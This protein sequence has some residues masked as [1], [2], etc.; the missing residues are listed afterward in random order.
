[1]SAYIIVQ[2]SLLEKWNYSHQLQKFPHHE[3]WKL[4]QVTD[5]AFEY[6]KG[7]AS[8]YAANNHFV[9][10]TALININLKEKN[11]WSQVIYLAKRKEYSCALKRVGK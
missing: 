1:M 2:V 5:F 8:D 11:I 9:Y 6:L 7:M 10:K 3:E 4:A